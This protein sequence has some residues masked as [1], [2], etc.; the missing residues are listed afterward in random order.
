MVYA[1]KKTI[2]AV[3]A[4]KLYYFDFYYKGV[5]KVTVVGLKGIIRRNSVLM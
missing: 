5:A 2:G 3:G 1:L 4:R